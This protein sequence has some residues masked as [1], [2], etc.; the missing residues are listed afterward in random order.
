MTQSDDYAT[1]LAALGDCRPEFKV[2]GRQELQD[3]R[4]HVA[5]ADAGNEYCMNAQAAGKSRNMVR[6]LK[7][8]RA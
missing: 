8:G 2:F 4:W 7:P 3:R 5:W 1:T 6:L